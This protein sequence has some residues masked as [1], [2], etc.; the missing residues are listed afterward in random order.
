MCYLQSVHN[1]VKYVAYLN[2]RH[3][4]NTYFF[5]WNFHMQIL[6]DMLRNFASVPSTHIFCAWSGFACMTRWGCMTAWHLS[7]HMNCVH[8]GSYFLHI[9]KDTQASVGFISDIGFAIFCSTTSFLKNVLMHEMLSFVWW[10]SHEYAVPWAF[11][12]AYFF[13]Q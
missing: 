7:I 3:G 10:K 5:E 4:V 12:S 1:Y 13:F 11:K 9:L 6:F 2:S 8:F